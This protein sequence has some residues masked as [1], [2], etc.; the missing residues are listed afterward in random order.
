MNI[1]NIGKALANQAL[2]STKSAVLD[3]PKPA[4]TPSAAAPVDVG[5]VIL[6]QI[7]AMQRSVKE[8]QELLVQLQAGGELLRVREIFVPTNHVLVFAGTDQY[9][10]TM[11]VITPATAAQVVCKIVKIPAGTTPIR[12]NILTPKSQPKPAA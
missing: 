8:E 7:Q 4:E 6:A 10:N 1:G 2:E 11:R 3:S 9:G 12:V 5:A